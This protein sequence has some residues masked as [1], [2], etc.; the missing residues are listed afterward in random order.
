M[1]STRHVIGFKAPDEKW[2]K[3]HKVWKACKD[4]GI[5]VPREVEKF[6]NYVAPE[7]A[8][9]ALVVLDKYAAEYSAGEEE[10]IEID[11]EAL[12]KVH[13]DLKIIRFYI[14]Y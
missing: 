13:P 11:L 3:M 14:A 10:G 8:H 9:G 6:F 4:A 12:R 2:V 5:A 7:S 1:G